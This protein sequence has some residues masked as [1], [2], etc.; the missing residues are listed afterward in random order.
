LTDAV[1]ED[2]LLRQPQAGDPAAAYLRKVVDYFERLAAEYGETP[3]GWTVRGDGQWLAA[4]L[5]A[6]LGGGK[7]AEEA[8]HKAPGARQKLMAIDPDDPKVLR[9]VADCHLGL[10]EQLARAGRH[11]EAE[12]SLR[13]ALAILKA[14]AAVASDDA[15]ER[16]L[17]SHTLGLLA[18]QL[19]AAGRIP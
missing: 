5:R 9:A 17:H 10:G 3:D 11:R 12:P 6:E 16:S 4:R 2:V 18:M 19:Q 1:V 8:D 13:E 15:D 14:L 7:S